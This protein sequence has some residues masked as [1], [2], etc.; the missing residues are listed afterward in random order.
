MG[1]YTPLQRNLRAEPQSATELSF[2]DIEAI[3]GFPLPPSARRHS[4]AWWSNEPAT[5]VQARAWLDAGWKVLWVKGEKVH[6]RRLEGA[7]PAAPKTTKATVEINLELLSLRA[8]R[9]ISDY[10]NESGGDLAAA[11]SRAIEEAATARRNQL[12]DSIR[13]NAPVVPGDSTDI[14]RADR[15][16]R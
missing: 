11:I 16:A 15:D 3:L 10:A 7:H 13:A 2:G 9:L 12:I 4:A 6:F 14:I 5:H 1:K 8:T